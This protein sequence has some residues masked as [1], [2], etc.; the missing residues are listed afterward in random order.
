MASVQY[1]NL[2][3]RWEQG[4]ISENMLRNYVKVGRITPEEFT[5]ITGIE[6]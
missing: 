5:E 2:K 6:Y 1:N 4:R 3:K